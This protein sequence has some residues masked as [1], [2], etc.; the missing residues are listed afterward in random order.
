MRVQTLP[1]SKGRE[2][3]F[4]SPV[5]F[6]SSAQLRKWLSDNHDKTRELWVG[7]YKKK[8]GKRSIT[9][10]ESVDEAL[11]FGWIDGVR[12]TLDDSRFVIRF[13][14]RR[15]RS[16]WSLN[17]TRRVMQLTKLG[18]MTTSGLQ[19]FAQRME[20]N[21]GVYSYEQRKGARLPDHYN[22]ELRSNKQAWTYFQAKPAGYRRV[23]SFW[24]VI[25]K[26]EETRLKRLGV[27]IAHSQLQ[28]DIPP[29]SFRRAKIP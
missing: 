22:R 3:F 11:C 18:R 6:Q 27:L 26:K 12:K 5:F 4:T 1:N 10:P 8:T 25:A 14:P 28:R 23:A 17:N 24:V 20:D 19:V 7:Y 15:S 13:T 9:W 16:I 2:E 29:L 21:S